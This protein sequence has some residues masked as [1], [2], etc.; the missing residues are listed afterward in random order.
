MLREKV[1]NLTREYE[2]FEE[3]IQENTDK[4][5]NISKSVSD[6]SSVAKIKNGIQKLLSESLSMDLKIN[7]LNHSILKYRQFTLRYHPVSSDGLDTSMFDEL[8]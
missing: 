3:K 4:F 2:E 7:I 6:T 1:Q 5:E 8:L